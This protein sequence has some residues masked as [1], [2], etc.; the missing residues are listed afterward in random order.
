MAT[1]NKTTDRKKSQPEKMDG[2]DLDQAPI[3]QPLSAEE[4]ARRV[5]RG[6]VEEIEDPDDV[7]NA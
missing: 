5:A 7:P 4:L 2:F 3:R 6:E 1:A